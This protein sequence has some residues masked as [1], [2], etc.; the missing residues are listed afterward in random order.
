MITLEQFRVGRQDKV[1]QQVVDTFRR[2]SLLLDKL[3]F[4]DC[5]VSNGGGSTLKY[6]YMRTK[7]PSVADFREIGKEYTPQESTR[8][9]CSVNVKI[10]GGSYAVDR[11]IEGASG[12]ASEIARQTEDKIR[13]TCNLF[14]KTVIQG[15]SDAD[16]KAFDGLDKALKGTKTEINAGSFLDVSTAAALDENYKALLDL[17][18]E[19]LSNLS[20]TPACIMANKSM[21]TKLK[22][23]ARRAGYLSRNGIPS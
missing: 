12:Q 11:V 19:F 6:G 9:E 20:G 21:I 8:E 3:V 17:L 10:F 18:D 22:G 14:H 1:D 4:D 15:D 13:A 7:V 5:L 23:A 16:E 2:N